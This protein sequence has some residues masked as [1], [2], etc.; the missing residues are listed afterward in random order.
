MDLVVAGCDYNI[1]QSSSNMKPLILV[2]VA[3]IARVKEAF[4]I[5]Y[6]H[7]LLITLKIAHEHVPPLDA[8]LADAILV[9][10]ENFDTGARKGASVLIKRNVRKL[11]ICDRT[12]R[13]REPKDRCDRHVQGCEEFGSVLLKCSRRIKHFVN[14]VE[15]KRLLNF[16]EDDHPQK[17]ITER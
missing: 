15:T 13:L 7:V 5:E 17:I 6:L 2:K 14:P 4:L 8:D 16:V 11:L 1:M 9:R 10:V 12:R 3:N